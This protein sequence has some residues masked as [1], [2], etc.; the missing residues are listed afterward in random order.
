MNGGSG[1]GRVGVV[2]QS[3]KVVEMGKRWKAG[4]TKGQRQGRFQSS[5]FLLSVLF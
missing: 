5:L 3:V 1:S 2:V 4:K